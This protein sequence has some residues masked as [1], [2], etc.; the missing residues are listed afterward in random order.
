MSAP[1]QRT[2]SVDFDGV[3][4]EYRTPWIAA[5]VIPD[6][7]VEGAI[8]WLWE[9]IQHFDVVIHSTRCRTWRGRRA[10]RRWRYEHSGEGWWYEG[11]GT[12]GIEDV[13]L[14]YGKRPS[15]IYLDDR[16]VRF[17]GK[18]P[19]V[20]AI[21]GSVPWNHATRHPRSTAE[22]NAGGAP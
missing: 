21:R 14:S 10:I 6:P 11:M 15:L 5:H 13:E 18:F 8:K 2:V 7:P 9:T 17:T 4:H 20:R 22:P 3:I 16:A 12:R 19:S 1:N